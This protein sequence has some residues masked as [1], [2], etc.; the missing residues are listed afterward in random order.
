L[1]LLS[2][3]KRAWC[4]LGFDVC[5]KAR[6]KSPPKLIDTKT[7]L[8]RSELIFSITWVQT[9]EGIDATKKQSEKSPPKSIDIK[10]S[11]FSFEKRFLIF[12]KAT[13][14]I[15]FFF[16]QKI[17]FFARR[18]GFGS[19]L[20]FQSKLRHSFLNFF[21]LFLPLRTTGAASPNLKIHNFNRP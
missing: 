2:F 1:F 18:R 9:L 4:E 11:P 3:S 16:F 20:S 19:L 15:I 8:S 17:Y 21:F 14:H 6:Q 5:Q 10:N 12:N 7:S 13:N